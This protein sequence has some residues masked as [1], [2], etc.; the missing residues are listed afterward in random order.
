[1][2]RDPWANLPEQ[3]KFVGISRAGRGVA[4]TARPTFHDGAGQYVAPDGHQ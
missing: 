3:F 4:F 2:I 1:M